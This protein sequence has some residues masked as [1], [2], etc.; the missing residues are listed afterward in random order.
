MHTQHRFGVTQSD[1]DLRFQ[2][3]LLPQQLHLVLLELPVCPGSMLRLDVLH[4][5]IVLSAEHV[6]LPLQTEGL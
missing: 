2:L 1:A 3:L 5:H 4:T 6:H